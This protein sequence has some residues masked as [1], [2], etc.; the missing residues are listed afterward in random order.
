VA[1][2]SRVTVLLLRKLCVWSRCSSWFVQFVRVFLLGTAAVGCSQPSAQ[3]VWHYSRRQWS[4]NCGHITAFDKRQQKLCSC[5]QSPACEQRRI[6]ADQSRSNSLDSNVNV[7]VSVGFCR[8][9]AEEFMCLAPYSMALSL[10]VA[11]LCCW[12]W[13]TVLAGSLC[14]SNS[15][16][17]FQHAVG[18]NVSKSAMTRWRHKGIEG[19]WVWRVR[20]PLPRWLVDL[21]NFPSE[22]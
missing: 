20:F 1:D 12:L 8:E 17:F 4:F 18:Q 7:P 3:C 6:S 16:L 5:H 2:S 19:K 10:L 22:V 21:R 9:A 11:V 13:Q 15:C 14:C